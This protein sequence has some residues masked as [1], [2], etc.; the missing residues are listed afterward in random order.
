MTLLGDV[1]HSL[2][3]YTRTQRWRRARTHI[4]TQPHTILQ[5]TRNRG[6]VAV[7]AV[8]LHYGILSY[9]FYLFYYTY[10]DI[11]ITITVGYYVYGKDEIQV[12]LVEV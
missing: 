2:V 4:H 11:R 12:T 7:C 9:T 5:G 10:S 3:M 6:C 1:I 8:V